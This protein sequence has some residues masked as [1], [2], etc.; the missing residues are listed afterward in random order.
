[1]PRAGISRLKT[2][3]AAWERWFSSFK[4]GRRVASAVFSDLWAARADPEPF[5]GNDTDA[6]DAPRALARLVKPLARHEQGY[7][8]AP[9]AGD[10]A[11]EW[12]CAAGALHR[13]DHSAERAELI[14]TRC[15]H[16]GCA[17]SRLALEGPLASAPIVHATQL[18]EGI[19]ALHWSAAGD[20]VLSA[21][22]GASFGPPRSI[23][24]AG[25]GTELTAESRVRLALPEALPHAERHDGCACEH[26]ATPAL[27]LELPEPATR[28]EMCP[29]ET[30]AAWAATDRAGEDTIVRAV[31]IA[32]PDGW[33]VHVLEPARM[34]GAGC[35]ARQFTIVGIERGE[36]HET[37]CDATACTTNTATIPEL[38][39]QQAWVVD[40]GDR[41]AVLHHDADGAL[42]ARRGRLDDLAASTPVMIVDA[43]SDFRPVGS[44]SITEPRRRVHRRSGARRMGDAA[45]GRR[46]I[47]RA[48]ADAALPA[49]AETL[50]TSATER[51]QVAVAANQASAMAYMPSSSIASLSGTPF[52]APKV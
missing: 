46:R 45:S 25:S 11:G 43:A 26:G 33:S 22:C 36:V 1:V 29:L 44:A 7:D 41:L 42:T 21:S 20:L 15:D 4:A 40:L 47:R 31:G 37:R 19:V 49:P 3:E 34:G 24:A 9:A 27:L 6:P 39:D 13:I 38:I 18:G 8:V 10:T 16:E 50:A 35:M 23:A 52:A 5:T 51:S 48:D 28:L 2:H 14:A 17:R 30:G 12:S 32:T